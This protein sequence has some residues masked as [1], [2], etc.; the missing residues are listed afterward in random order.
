M[1]NTNYSPTFP[2]FP[3]DAF[4]V[5]PSD[6]ANLQ[7]VA[8]IYIGAAG[9]TGSVRVTTAQGNIVTFAGLF[10]GTVIPLQV[11]RVWATGTDATSLVGI[12]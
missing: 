11:L 5:T 9:A 1:A 3:G 10:P 12:F 6:S 2:M 8:V 4:A 7:N